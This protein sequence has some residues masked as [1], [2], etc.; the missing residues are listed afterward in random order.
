MDVNVSFCTQLVSC[1][2]NATRKNMLQMKATR[3]REESQLIWNVLDSGYWVLGK[4]LGLRMIIVFYF[5]FLY[6]ASWY[7]GPSTPT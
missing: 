2:E 3:E 6:Q 7:Q 5:V 4:N 1:I